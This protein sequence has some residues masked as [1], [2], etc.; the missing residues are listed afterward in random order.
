[1][2][3]KIYAVDRTLSRCSQIYG[4]SGENKLSDQTNRANVNRI[5]LDEFPYI[6][7][8]PTTERGKNETDISKIGSHLLCSYFEYNGVGFG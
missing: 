7:I 3:A 5:V 2:Y 1:M 4:C 6:F 8:V